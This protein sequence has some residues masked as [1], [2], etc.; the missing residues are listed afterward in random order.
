MAKRFGAS[1]VIEAGE[2]TSNVVTDPDGILIGLLVP[3]GATAAELSFNEVIGDPHP[4]DPD[5]LVTVPLTLSDGATPYVVDIPTTGALVM[6]G[7]TTG[8][9]GSPIPLRTYNIISDTPQVAKLT[10]RPVYRTH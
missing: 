3:P 5:D 9:A 2:D 7:L 1:I 10:I 8:A 4:I 6:V